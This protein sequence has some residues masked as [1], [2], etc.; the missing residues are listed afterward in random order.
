[1][2]PFINVK[3]DHL[4]WNHVFH[5]FSLSEILRLSTRCSTTIIQ[6]RC[7]YVQTL[8]QHHHQ[9]RA[10]VNLREETILQISEEPISS[11]S[12]GA[13]NRRF[14]S[15]SVSRDSPKHNLT[16]NKTFN[17]HERGLFGAVWSQ[18]NSTAINVNLGIVLKLHGAFGFESFSKRVK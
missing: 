10:S 3:S 8:R 14:P 12:S 1:M 13:L 5:S 17:I 7:E 11:R 2:H 18:F 6:P 16:Y 4:C 15:S 9:P